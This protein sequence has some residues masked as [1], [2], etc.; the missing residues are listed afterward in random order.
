F[1]F[2]DGFDFGIGALY[3]T[4]E[5]ESEKETLL[6]AI[7]PFWDGN[8]VWLVVFGGSLFA[9][10]PSVYANLFSRNYLLMFGILGTLILR[11]LAPEFREQRHDEAW[12]RAWDY[13]FVAGSV[14]T[15]FLLGAF[16]SNW[17]LGDASFVA[18]VLF[19]VAVVLLT[20]VEGA[21]FLGIKT[22][23]KFRDEMTG[24]ARRGVV[25][26]LAVVVVILVYLY[27]GSGI[28]VVSTGG[29]VAVALTLVFAAGVVGALKAKRYYIAF[30]SAAG[31]NFTLVGLIAYL[32]HPFVD[33]AAN[34]TIADAVIS[35][36]PLNLMTVASAFLIPV[37]LVYFGVLYS[38]FSGPV[39]EGEGY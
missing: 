6:G 22:R 3:A 38:V 20:V 8:E 19:G 9:V 31:M 4:R 36:L 2:L 10:F 35:T 32:L 7:G 11:G 23:G 28:N 13:I 25:G 17:L 24:Y 1:L 29:V 5:D 27:I 33:P 14:G 30:A 12:K 34:L 39:E 18:A 15:T 26:Y 16:V 37:V 21:T